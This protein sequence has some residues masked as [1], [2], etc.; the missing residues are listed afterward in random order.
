MAKISGMAGD[1]VEDAI[2]A[3]GAAADFAAKFACKHAFSA[4][5]EWVLADA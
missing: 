4:S 1:E 5:D 2:A 3:A